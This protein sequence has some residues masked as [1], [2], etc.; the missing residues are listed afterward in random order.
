MDCLV[1]A[2]QAAGRLF[3]AVP[4]EVTGVQ[5][6]IRQPHAVPFLHVVRGGER[7][8]LRRSTANFTLALLRNTRYLVIIV[9][10]TNIKHTQFRRILAWG[11]FREDRHQSR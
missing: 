4:A 2:D 5:P 6:R 9:I 7:R 8:R 10:P 1:P 3:T 11:L